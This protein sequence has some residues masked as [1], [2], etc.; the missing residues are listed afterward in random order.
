MFILIKLVYKTMEKDLQKKINYIIF[1]FGML[2]NTVG[3]IISLFFNDRIATIITAVSWILNILF[4]CLFIFFKKEFLYN[5][6]IMFLLGFVILP[7]ILSSTKKSYQVLQYNYILPV[8]YALSVNSIS[9]V[10]LPISNVLLISVIAFYKINLGAAIVFFLVATFQVLLISFFTIKLTEQNKKLSDA[11]TR[12]VLTGMY[13][14]YG[15]LQKINYNKEVIAIMFDIDHFKEV[16]D[17]YGHYEGDRIIKI[18]SIIIRNHSDDKFISCRWGGEEFLII[19]EYSFEQVIDIVKTIYNDIHDLLLINNGTHVTISCG[20]SSKGKMKT[21]DNNNLIKEADDNLY[22]SKN[23][24]RARIT[25]Q[26]K[27]IYIQ[28]RDI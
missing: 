13:N 20:I 16:N 24:G 12:D 23:N 22:F 26:G 1:T 2:L 10:L 11:S 4:F 6:Y 17:K 21:I 7:I 5:S 28:A 15:L 27:V 19:T 9:K 14:R 8:I 25:Y 3:V 18:L